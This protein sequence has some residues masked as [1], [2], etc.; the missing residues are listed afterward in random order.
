MISKLTLPD[1]LVSFIVSFPSILELFHVKINPD[2]MLKWQKSKIIDL[3][4]IK[5]EVRSNFSSMT[6]I[7]AVTIFMGNLKKSYNL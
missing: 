1:R 7:G 6:M 4:S 3:T 2:N 5:R